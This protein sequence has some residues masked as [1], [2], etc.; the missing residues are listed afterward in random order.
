MSET[1]AVG[2]IYSE[3]IA[4]A[5]ADD[6]FRR[7]LIADP[8]KVLNEYGFAVPKDF[9]VTVN[10]GEPETNVSFDRCHLHLPLPDRPADLDP[11]ALQAVLKA[12]PRRLAIPC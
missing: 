1:A 4:R 7:E 6:D 5:W 8:K 2:A 10:P 3:I 11:P 9:E 12:W